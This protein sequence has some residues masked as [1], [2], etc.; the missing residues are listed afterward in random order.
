[1]IRVG[2]APKYRR[3]KMTK[4]SPIEMTDEI[5]G[6]RTF[7]VAMKIETKVRAAHSKLNT[8]C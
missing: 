4:M 3:D 7:R 5:L 8:D 1:M 2:P 6:S